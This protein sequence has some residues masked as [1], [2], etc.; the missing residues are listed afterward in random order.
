MKKNIFSRFQL[1]ARAYVR[2]WALP[3]FLRYY[4]LV[5]ESKGH[6]QDPIYTGPGKFLNLHRFAFRSHGPEDTCKFVN[7][8]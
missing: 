3:S 7:G 8:K 4:F 6:Y 2:I 1:Y 5:L